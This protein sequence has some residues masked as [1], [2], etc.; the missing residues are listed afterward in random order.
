MIFRTR[1]GLGL[2]YTTR[3]AGRT[4]ALLH[5]IALD[6]RFWQPVAHRLEAHC[7]V[8]CIDLRGHGGSD[9][10]PHG[11]SLDEMAADVVELLQAV[12]G[13]RPVI[14]GCS[15]GGM[16]AQAIALQQPALAGGIVI[17][18]STAAQTPQSR[19]AILQRAASVAD[20]MPRLVPQTLARW[21]ST[22]F[23]AEQPQI[24][25]LVAQWLQDADP[26][27][28]AW[29]W[30]A[31]AALDYAPR[32]LDID[33]PALVVCSSLDTSCP[34]AA[35]RAIAAAIPRAAYEEIEG[36]AHMA[37]L[38]QPQRFAEIV[39]RFITH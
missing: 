5:P 38:E 23:Q 34:P 31:I 28:H 12:G 19:E 15:L 29:T 30:R 13:E 9:V 21:F 35:G 24:V 14:V 25:E 10:P 26:I 3:G 32:L 16:V 27:V 20:G 18:N 33:V 11:F 39:E 17:A 36:A 2:H 1:A 8:M 37:P 7:R 4:V 22:T 6:G